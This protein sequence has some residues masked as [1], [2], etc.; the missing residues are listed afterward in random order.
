MIEQMNREFNF[1][2][3]YPLPPASFK[4]LGIDHFETKILIFQKKSQHL[5]ER[6]YVHDAFVSGFI[7]D[8]FNSHIAPL[9][10][11]NKEHRAKM[12]LESAKD[13]DGFDYQVNKLLYQVKTNKKTAPD[14]ARCLEKV[15]ALKTQ[16]K[17][18]DLTWPEWEKAKL[19]PNKV[20]AYLRKVLKKQHLTEV[21]KI[22]FVKRDFG[23][24]L[25]AFSRKAK[26]EL[27]KEQETQYWPLN[28]L[29][30][31]DDLPLFQVA[32]A[33]FPQGLI[34]LIQR[35][36]REYRHQETPFN[37]ME[38]DKTIDAFLEDFRFTGKDG[39]QCRFNDIQEHDLSL[40]LQKKYSLLNW[41]MGSGKTAASYAWARFNLEK[42]ALK[43]I[44]IISAAI[45]INLTW[46][47]FMKRH[48]ENY[49]LVSS[50]TDIQNLK[51]G[52]FA[53]VSL[54]QLKDKTVTSQDKNKFPFRLYKFL[55]EYLRK[56]SF[57]V[58]LVFD[59]SDEITN[60]NS[61]QSKAVLACFRKVK[62][63]LLATGTT[64]RNN[65]TE[66]YKQLELLYNNSVN[67]L[68]TCQTIYSE[69]RDKE[70]EISIQEKQNEDFFLKPFP[71]DHGPNLFKA[72]FNPSKATVF[73][74]EKH[75]QDIYNQD[76]LTAMIKKTII[77]RLFKEIAGPDRYEIK[78]HILRQNDC[79]VMLYGKIIDELQIMIREYFEST[80]NERKDRMLQIIR[81]LNLLMKATST[82]HT[83]KEYQDAQRSKQSAEV[84]NM[85]LFRHLTQD[86][87]PELPNKYA[88]IENLVSE[89]SAALVAIGCTTHE[90]VN[91]YYTRFVKRF[92]E[93]QVFLCTGETAFAERNSLLKNFE[94]SGNGILI[95]TQ[96]SLKSSVNIPTCNEIIIEALPW[97]V[98]KLLQFCFRFVR[99][100]SQGKSF[101]HIVNYK[102]TID[103][104]LYAL[105]MAKE[106]I[107][108]FV[109][110]LEFKDQSDIYGEFDVD[111]DILNSILSKTRDHEGKV[112]IEWGLQRVK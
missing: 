71:A 69:V 73:G 10:Q 44:F 110:T 56:N 4:A 94:S 111:L 2:L 84:Q 41:Q 87:G 8:L 75:N 23:I 26:I 96:Q 88:Y 35:K 103:L 100:D 81:Q 90:A 108:D 16:E 30:L 11:K 55:R 107:N 49:I 99:Y 40:C 32:G 19:T 54:S 78:S 101:I 24:A 39:Q 65:I 91:M 106:R 43:N 68:C 92:P 51:P 105:L 29:I 9:K 14:Y 58:G 62:C 37:E 42:K 28:D 21:D 74:I 27:N 12:L 34:N 31:F 13:K 22:A 76:S 93:R 64:T 59:E 82:P 6:P 46:V 85:P 45:S 66:L 86:T 60:P 50:L 63:K 95:S 36:K 7:E 20:I 102:D 77:T 38:K 48:N 89:R 18:Y 1:V 17:P 61:K 57:R 112:K 83:F 97:N 79:E 33:P 109:K 70:K 67:M 3:Q 104:N 80:G 25:K 15:N 72:C 53:L 5:D 47:P 52:M 98:A